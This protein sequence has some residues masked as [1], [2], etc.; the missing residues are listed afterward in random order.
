MQ[1]RI[2]IALAVLLAAAGAQAQQAMSKDAFRAQ[3]KAIEATY[4]AHQAR[5]KPHKGNQREVCMARVRGERD[6]AVAELDMRFKPSAKN[7]EKLRMARAEAN[8]DVAKTQCET[9]EGN[10]KEVCQ[11]DAKAV[12]AAA[13]AEAKL[14]NQVAEVHR[15]SDAVV[16]DRSQQQLA[17][18]EAQFAA[19]RER[20]EMLQGEA[21]N[22][23]LINARKRFGKL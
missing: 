5:C 6:I 2:A 3:K 23:C 4:D 19:A 20:C 9:M 17:Q 16:Q 1:R 12:L 13:E 7:D 22:D 14:Q 15:R 21:R 10:A 11:K 8:Y 18:M